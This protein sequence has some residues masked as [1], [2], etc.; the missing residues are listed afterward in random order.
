M[1]AEIRAIH[2]E[3]R[4]A[5]GAP[6][7]HAELRSRGCAINRKR[8]T[9]LMRSHASS[10]GTCA[11]PDARRPRIQQRRRFRIWCGG[12]SPPRLSIRNG[13]AT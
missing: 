5:Y 12:T 3:H 6:R 1:V 7:V 11:V 2:F 8:V 4:S 9:R 13:A 10:A